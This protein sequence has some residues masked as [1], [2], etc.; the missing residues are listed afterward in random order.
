MSGCP[1]FRG[2]C[3]EVSALSSEVL[4]FQKYTEKEASSPPWPQFTHPYNERKDCMSPSSLPG[5]M[6]WD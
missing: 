2:A 4:Y 5:L 1:G 6:P 3:V